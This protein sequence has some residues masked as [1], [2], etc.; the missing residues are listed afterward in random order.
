V[1]TRAQPLVIAAFDFD[2]TL[3]HGGS[4]WPFLAAV[5]GRRRLWA[6]ALRQAPQLLAGAVLGGHRADTAKEALFE[7]VLAGIPVA[8]AANSAAAF[9]RRHFARHARADVVSR[10]LA[11]AD[12]GHHIVVV[13]ASPE[14]Y[15]RTVADSLG[16]DHLIATA[17]AVDPAGY[18]TGRYSGANCRGEE[19]RRR[20]FAYVEQ[21]A[22]DRGVT[23]QIWAY[24]NSA[25]DRAMLAGADIAVNVGRLGRLGRLGR[26]PRLAQVAGPGPST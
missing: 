23:A 10:L 19:K 21:L 16:A 22:A 26:F 7:S 4:V 6:G 3:T 1:V 9:G 2:G 13:S 25:G 20:L 14:L 17:L 24:G 18:L 8:V 15:L 12:A 5:G 11:H